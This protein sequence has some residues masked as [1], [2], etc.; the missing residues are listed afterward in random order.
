MN[1]QA[2]VAKVS[3]FAHVLRDQ[4]VSY[5]YQPDLLSALPQDGRGARQPDRRS[6]DAAR[7]CT[8]GRYQGPFGRGAGRRAGLSVANVPESA[9]SV[10]EGS[11]LLLRPVPRVAWSARITCREKSSFISR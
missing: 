7:E 8:L 3:N 9:D 11:T 2:L 6:L 10:P 4:G 5:Q 1:A